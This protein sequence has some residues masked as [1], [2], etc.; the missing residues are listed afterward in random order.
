MW[1]KIADF[2]KLIMR[3]AYDYSFE[4]VAP[5][6]MQRFARKDIMAVS[7]LW[8]GEGGWPQ[9]GDIANLGASL[10]CFSLLHSS[11]VPA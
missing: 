5:E 3:G 8:S 6:K 10:S 2:M 9:H 4:R 11:Q 1:L 7:E